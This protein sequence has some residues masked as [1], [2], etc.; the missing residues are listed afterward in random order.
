MDIRVLLNHQQV[1]RREYRCPSQVQTRTP[2]VRTSANK[3]IIEEDEQQ[4]GSSIFHRSTFPTRETFFWDT[5]YIIIA[6]QHNNCIALYVKDCPRLYQSL[7]ETLADSY[8]LV[9]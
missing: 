9:L 2:Q 3:C 6:N 8:H 5:L 4:Y 7:L 1:Q